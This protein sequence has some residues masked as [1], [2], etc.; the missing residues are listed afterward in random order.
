MLI[1][2]KTNYLLLKFKS[3]KP[4]DNVIIIEGILNNTSKIINKVQRT[5]I[6]RHWICSVF[7]IKNYS[8]SKTT[9]LSPNNF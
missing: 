1:K 4:S 9:C 3:F 8:G 7:I 2:N 6:R 5:R